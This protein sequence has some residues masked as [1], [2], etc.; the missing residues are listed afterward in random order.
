[1]SIKPRREL[2]DASIGWRGEFARVSVGVVKQ[3]VLYA[4][5]A[6]GGLLPRVTADIDL[7]GMFLMG[8]ALNGADIVSML[9]YA[10]N[11]VSFHLRL[12]GTPTEAASG[13]PG[14]AGR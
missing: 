11:V 3:P 5:G 8:V 10:R 13:T 14:A 4:F 9:P 12:A 6:Q 1:M 2:Y 7:L